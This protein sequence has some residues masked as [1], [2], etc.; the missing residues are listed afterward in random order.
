MKKGLEALDPATV[1]PGG[2]DGSVSPQCSSRNVFDNFPDF[3]IERSKERYGIRSIFTVWP[4]S[5][6]QRHRDEQFEPI[7]L[8]IRGR[9]AASVRQDFCA[10]FNFCGIGPKLNTKSLNGGTGESDVSLC[11]GT[12]R[13]SEQLVLVSF[14]EGVENG[15]QWRE[16]RMPSIV[17]L[18][19]LNSCSHRV[20]QAGNSPLG[21]VGTGKTV[22][23]ITQRESERIGL[24]RRLLPV[25]IENCNSID[26]MIKSGPQNMDNVSDHESPPDCHWLDAEMGNEAVSGKVAIVLSRDYVGV[27]VPPAENFTLDGL[28]MFVSTSQLG[29]N[30]SEV[31][32]HV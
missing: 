1:A 31:K 25:S 23:I 11:R 22:G 4:R 16:F 29:E 24:R 27:A 10:L 21:T 13:Q 15:K 20:T 28:S 8:H 14:F 19:S 9:S 3:L 17:R 32:I 6:Q 12:E 7:E 30:T 5:M 18:T 26:E 2:N